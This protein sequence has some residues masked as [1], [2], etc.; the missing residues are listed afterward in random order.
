MSSL[1]FCLSVSP[2]SQPCFNTETVNLVSCPGMAKK[3]N[4]AAGCDGLAPGILKL[5]NVTW[6]MLLTF[7]F[8]VV[9]NGHYPHEWNKQQV[10]NIFKKG[11]RSDT[12]NYR[13][14]S[15][16]GAISKLYDMVLASRFAQ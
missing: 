3:M 11:D 12:N 10:F 9:F 5:L 4:K 15:I 6:I 1:S 16:M 8:N 13:G 7:L 2:F 14:I